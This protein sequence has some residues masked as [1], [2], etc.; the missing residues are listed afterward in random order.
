MYYVISIVISVILITLN[1]KTDVFKRIIRI[2][3]IILTNKKITESIVI[4]WLILSPILFLILW[5]VIANA[6]SFETHTANNAAIISEP[7]YWKGF[8][9]FFKD[10]IIGLPVV[11][12]VLIFILSA[13]NSDEIMKNN[14]SERSDT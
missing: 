10:L 5:F 12:L 9:T 4:G 6:L 8:I 3:G 13:S 11:V 1:C 7:Y 14:N 2:A